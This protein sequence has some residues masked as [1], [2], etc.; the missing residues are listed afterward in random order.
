[1]AKFVYQARNTQAKLIEGT[2]EAENQSQAIEKLHALGLYPIR[3][4]EGIGS[5]RLLSSKISASY[6]KT[7]S[8]RSLW[9]KSS[10]IANFTRQ[11]ADLLSAG[12]SLM[13]A[14]TVLSNQTENTKL[15]EIV[16]MVR[17]EVQGGSTLAD[18]MAKHPKVFNQLFVS[19]VRA[20]EIGGLL[21]T[22]LVRLADFSEKESEMRGKILTAMAYPLVL[23]IVGTI[24]VI[25]LITFIIPRFAA[26]FEELGVALPLPT[27]ILMMISRIMQQYWW[28]VLL[29]GSIIGIAVYRFIKSAEGKLRVNQLQLRIPVLG[30]IIR[31]REIARFARTFGELLKNGVP[32]LN[33]LQISADTMTNLLVAQEI[34]K[35]RTNISEGE[36]IAEPLRQSAIFPPMVVNM[37]AV[38]EESGHLESVLMKIANS[39]EADV[40]RSLKVFTSLL[41]PA[42]ILCMACI[43]GFIA[44]AMLLPVFTINLN[45]GK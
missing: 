12:L 44:L 15:R 10:E 13:N 37:I 22:V 20:G 31:K 8:A 16:K 30:T 3:V 7:G 4:Q 14:L 19:M 1:M 40:D 36:R 26:I 11:L 38:G 9:I 21:E 27:Q 42:V 41:E 17:N 25:F 28:I 5:H 43:V 18:A 24:A 39:Y 32:I 35:I 23:V 2:L 34:R 33:A 6:K 45:V 29:G